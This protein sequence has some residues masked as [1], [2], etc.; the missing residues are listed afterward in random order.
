[1]LGVNKTR[2]TPYHLQSDGFA[3]RFNRTLKD[4]L[5]KLIDSS[6]NA[7]DVWIPH[8]LFAYHAYSRTRVNRSHSLPHA[9]W[10]ETQIPVDI[11][12]GCVT[13]SDEVPTD[14]PA[15]LQKMQGMFERGYHVAITKLKKS[16]QRYRDYYDSK[17]NGKS[18]KV[19][20]EVWLFQAHSRKGM[21]II[22]IMGR[23]LHS[24]ESIIRCCLPHTEGWEG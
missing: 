12:V 9:L 22:E 23:S 1:M 21:E 10:R 6:Q 16:T 17:A 18:F 19:G 13:A 20:D 7:W 4:M 3:Q 24:S 14:A 8:S 11:L 2:T 5:A 15:Y